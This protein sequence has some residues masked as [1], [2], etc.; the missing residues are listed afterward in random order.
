MLNLIIQHT[1]KIMKRFTPILVLFLG[2]LAIVALRPTLHEQLRHI[3]S[4]VEASKMTEIDAETLSSK[5]KCSTWTSWQ[6]GGINSKLSLKVCQDRYAGFIQLKNDTKKAVRLTLAVTFN[7]GQNKRWEIN[8]QPMSTSKAIYCYECNEH[9][10][11]LKSWH[12]A[13]VHFD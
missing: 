8:L 11:G 9:H 2:F 3:S 5:T 7:D 6:A 12:L 10:N 1:Y 13:R 4:E